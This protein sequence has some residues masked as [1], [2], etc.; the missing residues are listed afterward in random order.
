MDRLW[1]VSGMTEGGYKTH[2]INGK[3][4][5]TLIASDLEIF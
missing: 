2:D 1:V 5:K 4:Q 3:E